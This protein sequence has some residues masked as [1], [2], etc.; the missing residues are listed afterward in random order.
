MFGFAMRREYDGDPSNRTQEIP[1]KTLP[2]LTQLLN[3]NPSPQPES[4]R[5]TSPI[6]IR[7]P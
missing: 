7:S 1:W 6:A 2:G 4:R 3:P 5:W